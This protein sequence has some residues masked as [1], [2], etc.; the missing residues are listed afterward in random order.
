M[1]LFQLVIA[2]LFQLFILKIFGISENLDI[3]FASNTINM[4]IVT[5][6]TSALNYS[7]T[8]LFVKYFINRR[9]KTFKNLA[10][11]LLNLLFIIFL[12]LAILQA[13]FSTEITATIFPGFTGQQN[14]LISDMFA[15]QAFISIVSILIGVLNAI[16]Y[17]FNNLYRTVVFPII[18]S[19]LQI[20]FVYFTYESIGIFSLVYALGLFQVFTFLGLS[21]SF[22]KYYEFKIKINK[23]LKDTWGKMYPL[24]LSSSFS[25]S[26]ILVDRYFSSA[27]VV[28]SIT[29]LHYGQLFIN[30]LTTFVNKGISLVSLRKFS[31]IMEDKEMFN[32]Y[33]LNV[34][35]IM[36]VISMFVILEVIIASDMVLYY[37]LQG[38]SFSEERLEMLYII[39]ISFLGVFLGGV[40]SSVLVNAFYSKGLTSLVSKMSIT[41]HVIGIVVKIIT[42]KLYGFYA[43][44]IVM[45]IKSI[46]NSALLLW[47]Y[48]T[49]IY[50][51]DYMGFV[52]FFCKVLFVS[53][54]ILIGTLWLKSMNVNIFVL[55]IIS[56]LVYVAVYYKFLKSKYLVMKIK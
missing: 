39:I 10:N 5:V 7:T 4:I 26:D 29:I 38:D 32:G 20:G 41:L 3:Y 46:V 33:F 48:N 16:N 11:S 25:K 8:P 9:L 1:S 17:T 52:L 40:L 47:F 42:F 36:L 15:I 27:L 55:I 12:V 13:I 35:Q 54:C 2:F 24:I 34:Y 51:I 49:H 22:I 18:G 44:A 21:A 53:I 43:L 23:T 45:S 14:E 6:A 50:K 28:G 30:I 56:S 37:L 31:T 19:I